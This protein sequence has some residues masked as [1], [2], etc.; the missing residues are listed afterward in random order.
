MQLPAPLA[1]VSVVLSFDFDGTLHDPSAVPTVPVRFFETVQRLRESH[2][3]VWGLNTG[4]SMP[5]ALEGLVDARCPVAPDYLVARE[6]EIYFPN[7]F[8]RWVPDEAWNKRCAKD[9]HTLFKKHRKLLARIR[10]EVLAHTG[11]EWL[12]MEGEPAGLIARREED[13]EWIMPR[14]IELAGDVPDLG[15]QRNSI[16]LRFGHK[17][18]QKGSS[19]AE[20][21]SRYGVPV[22]GRFAIGDSHNDFE[23]LDPAN[24]GMIACPSNSVEELRGHVRALGGYVCKTSHG[25]GAVEA[26]GHFFGV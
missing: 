10:E 14:V 19:L 18:Y 26:L 5:Y 8:G 9:I 24:T 3:A 20:V 4:R 6:R 21:A 17:N 7:Q 23:M 15:W 22:E 2:G 13:M 11:A 16:Y 12:E 25:D 1:K